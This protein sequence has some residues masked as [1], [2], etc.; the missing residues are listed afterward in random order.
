MLNLEVQ[1]RCYLHIIGLQDANLSIP[2]V[3]NGELYKRD[4]LPLENITVWF[5]DHTHT[6][7]NSTDTL[8]SR[9]KQAYSLS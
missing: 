2:T 3:A 8:R 9:V 5:F 6:E 1:L 7:N 4:N